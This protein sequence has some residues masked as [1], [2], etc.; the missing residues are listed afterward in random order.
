MELVII[1]LYKGEALILATASLDKT[2]CVTAAYTLV[3][4]NSYNL[5][6][7]NNN[8]PA[9]STI[10][11]QMIQVLPST[12]PTIEKISALFGYGLLLSIIAIGTFKLFAKRLVLTSPP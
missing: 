10:S 11:S 8:V 2:P 3:A 12:S 4:P 6:T 9:V 7:A 5:L 1:S